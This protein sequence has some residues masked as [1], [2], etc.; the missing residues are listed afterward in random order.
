MLIQDLSL[1]LRNLRYYCAVM[2][3]RDHGVCKEEILLLLGECKSISPPPSLH[4]FF[5]SFIRHACS[6]IHSGLPYLLCRYL[7]RAEKIVSYV[8]MLYL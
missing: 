2:W 4:F 8:S 1:I 6:V 3:S 7:V 5:H